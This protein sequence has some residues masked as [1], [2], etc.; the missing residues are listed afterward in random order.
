AFAVDGDPD[1]Q[2]R[3]VA[4]LRLITSGF[5]LG[6][7]DSLIVHTGT[8]GG[9]VSTYPEPFRRLGHLRLS[10][11]LEDTDDLLADLR[12]ALDATFR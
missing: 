3:F 10:V 5:S 2:N 4:N 8:E 1:T 6:H 7:D 11:G 12:A 9:R